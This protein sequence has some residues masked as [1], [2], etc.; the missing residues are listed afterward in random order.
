MASNCT[1]C[2]AGYYFHKSECSTSCPEGYYRE[3]SECLQE[4]AGVVYL[5]YMIT[6]IV[7][8]SAT[9]LLKAQIAG[10]S[11]FSSGVC[12]VS[13]LE[14][15]LLIQ[16]TVEVRAKVTAAAGRSLR[17]LQIAQED[18]EE[19]RAESFAA[20][21]SGL[22]YC[23]VVHYLLNLGWLSYYCR[24]ISG[25]SRFFEWRTKEERRLHFSRFVCGV[26]ALGSFKF[27]RVIRSRLCGW[28]LLSATF[29]DA[30][31]VRRATNL[32]ALLGGVLVSLPL[33]VLAALALRSYDS[34]APRDQVFYF[35]IDVIVFEVLLVLLLLADGLQ[36]DQVAENRLPAKVHSEQK[37]Q[38]QLKS[39]E[40]NPNDRSL[41]NSSLNNSREMILRNR[42]MTEKGR[43]LP[44]PIK[45]EGDQEEEEEEKGGHEVEE[46]GD[47]G[48][49][50]SA[51]VKNLSRSMIY[52]SQPA[53][54]RNTPFSKSTYFG[55]GP[56]ARGKFQVPEKGQ[57]EL[58]D[59]ILSS[60]KAFISQR[61]EEPDGEH[62]NPL[63]NTSP[64]KSENQTQETEPV[65]APYNSVDQANYEIEL[66]D[67]ENSSIR[68]SLEKPDE[69]IAESE[70]HN[71]LNSSP[72]SPLS[73]FEASRPKVNLEGEERFF[74]FF[75]SFWDH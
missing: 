69:R 5:P 67:Q 3:G 17:A 47:P 43:L 51:N 56:S 42:K 8:V 59:Q 54:E 49:R 16:Y 32:F 65:K 26:S 21:F 34:S 60:S 31:S 73:I 41:N 20:L 45:D 66:L 64:N 25:D 4:K 19:L 9:L 52:T 61:G 39:D 11:A 36:R 7:A 14:V 30:A 40:E 70:N 44:E 24:S 1:A 33:T 55:N 58:E 18:N 62:L 57:E 38:D 50:R 63:M 72:E 37:Y 74:F 53:K 13:L 71:P 2:A 29:S 6:T 22:I 48:R 68:Q 75:N 12:L 27:W 28:E 10:A 46:K 15:A 23:L 35:S